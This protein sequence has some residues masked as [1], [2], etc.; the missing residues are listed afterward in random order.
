MKKEVF[1][2]KNVPVIQSP[3]HPNYAAS[4]DGKIFR[5]ST[6]K[7]MS[8][9]F[10]STTGYYYV[11]MCHNNKAT[12]VRVNR[13]VA[14]CWVDNPH[15]DLYD[16]VNHKDG[17]KLND[18]DDNLEWCTGS[19]NQR[20]AVETGLKGK[21]EKLYNSQLSDPEVHEI[22]QKLQEGYKINELAEEYR[23]S[24]D[25]IRK[26]RGGD[27]YFHIRKLYVNIP[28]RYKVELSEKTVRWV[29]EQIL[30]G[31]GDKSIAKMSTN[32]HVTAIECKRI[33][34]KIRYSLISN[35]YF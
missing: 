6:G 28:H 1:Y 26:I 34:Y 10:N 33:R 29:C 21:G 9:T 5:V 8:K 4:Y 12:T 3:N 24:K 19:Q 20:H 30:L 7:E 23:V 35:E 18:H 17:D 27:T 15:P 32:K 22:C 14:F 11:R 2:I 13:V 31:Y 25:I 16:K